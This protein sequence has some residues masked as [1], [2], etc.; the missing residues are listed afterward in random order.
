MSSYKKAREEIAKFI[1]I[2]TKELSFILYKQ[3][4]DSL[5]NTFEIPKKS[6]GFRIINAPVEK[7]KK[8]K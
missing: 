6:G 4:V 3:K 1:G 7:L 8:Y 2:E 5:Y